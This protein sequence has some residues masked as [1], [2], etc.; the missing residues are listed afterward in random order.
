[1]RFGCC[2]PIENMPAMRA[3]GYDYAELRVVDLRPDD[4]ETYY[5]PIKRRIEDAGLPPE[6]PE[7]CSSRRITQWWGRRATWRACA[8]M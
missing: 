6:A 1:M 5:A 3:A 8:L 2:G 7:T 4:D